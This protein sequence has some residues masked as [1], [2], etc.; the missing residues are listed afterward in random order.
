MSRETGCSSRCP[1]RSWHRGMRRSARRAARRRRSRTRRGHNAPASARCPGIGC[2]EAGLNGQ[3]AM[4]ATLDQ[5]A[6]LRAAVGH[7]GEVDCLRCQPRHAIRNCR[8][9]PGPVSNV[10]N[11]S[12]SNLEQPFCTRRTAFLLPAAERAS[13]A[14]ERKIAAMSPRSVTDISPQRSP[15]KTRIALLSARSAS[16][17]GPARA[18]SGHP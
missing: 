14:S 17:A 1:P 4:P 6:A 8:W 7:G 10:P 12:P 13:D 18:R 5:R 3:A 9:L 11:T 16:V 2:A 15:G